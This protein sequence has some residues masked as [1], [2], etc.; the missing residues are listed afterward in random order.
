M[1]IM[2]SPDCLFSLSAVVSRAE[3]KS[4]QRETKS[5]GPSLPVSGS[6]THRC[7]TSPWVI[8]GL[9]KPSAVKMLMRFRWRAGLHVGGSQCSALLKLYV[10]PQVTRL[11]NK[12]PRGV[13]V[14]LTCLDV[15]SL[16]PLL[17]SSHQFGG[18][19][20]K[21]RLLPVISANVAWKPLAVFFLRAGSLRRAPFLLVSESRPH[22]NP[23]ANERDDECSLD[24]LKSPR[25]LDWVWQAGGGDGYNG[26][27]QL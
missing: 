22:C 9:W 23:H 10:N 8:P 13:P 21:A 18:K 11:P 1:S 14:R 5:S 17:T 15:S 25:R 4:D 16:K 6:R 2:N 27:Q 19:R 7:H 12:S 26:L 3:W 24:Q 20:H